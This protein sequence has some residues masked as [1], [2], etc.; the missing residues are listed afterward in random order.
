VIVFVT[1]TRQKS[2]VCVVVVST[3]SSFV[4]V[5]LQVVA[6]SNVLG[7]SVLVMVRFEPGTV[8]MMVRFDVRKAVE[9]A[10]VSVVVTVRFWP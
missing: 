3:I 4:F 6:E 2:D 1:L 5:T 9:A 8:D 10:I 7:R